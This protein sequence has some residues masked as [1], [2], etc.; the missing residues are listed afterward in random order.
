MRYTSNPILKR[1]KCQGG[2]VR[3][4]AIVRYMENGQF[5]KNS[6]I[7]YWP[8]SG[9]AGARADLRPNMA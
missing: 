1:V 8:S 3:I 4:C 5:T 2:W 7:S 9:N 6:R